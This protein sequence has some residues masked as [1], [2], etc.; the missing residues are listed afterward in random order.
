MGVDPRPIDLPSAADLD[1]ANAMGL[2]LSR[3]EAAAYHRQWLAA[4]ADAYTKDVH[5][6]LDEATKVRA[7][8]YLQAQRYRAEF[9]T[10]MRRLLE[11]V[12]ALL[13]PTTLVAAPRRVEAD[14]YLVSLSRNCVPWSFVGFPAISVPGGLTRTGLPIGL[15]FVSAP[16]NDGIVLAL[17][18]ALER[19]EHLDALYDLVPVPWRLAF[20][21]PCSSSH[22]GC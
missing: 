14:R 16:A 17:A 1:A 6:Q 5:D 10:R 19:S 9:G 8:D 22:D 15:Q 18:A 4:H 13:M 12:D 7:V 20:C 3:C 21:S 2:V 11:E